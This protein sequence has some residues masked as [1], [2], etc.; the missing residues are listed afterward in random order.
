MGGRVGFEL[1]AY[2]PERFLS[3]ILGAQTPGSRN[4]HGNESDR[5]RIALF[6]K[7][8]EALKRVMA[9]S[10]KEYESYL[11]PTLNGDLK[12]YTAKTKANAMR[13]DISG[14]LVGLTVPCL[15]YAGESDSLAHES[16]KEH[17]GKMPT[18]RFVSLPGLNHMESIARTDMIIPMVSSFLNEVSK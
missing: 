9:R 13:E 12:A 3:F 2:H 4:E 6:E 11:E 17:S 14:H 15:V 5:K 7:G 16:A 8:P 18:A 1:A 10:K